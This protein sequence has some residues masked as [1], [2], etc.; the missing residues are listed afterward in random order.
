MAARVAINGYGRIGR[1]VLRAAKKYKKDIEF[2][3]LHD[4]ADIESM[5]MVTKYDSIHGRFPGE[6]AIRGDKLVIDGTEIQV[7]QGAAPKGG[8][9]LALPWAKYGVDYVVEST[10]IFRA[11]SQLKSHLTS[12]AKRV[13][14]T[15]PSKDPL[16]ATI[17]MGVNDGVLRPDHTIISNSS[18]TTNCTAPVAQVLHENWGIRSGYLSTV[19]AFTND[20]RLFDF[21]HKDFRRA[22]MATQSIIPT[23]TGAAE[24]LGRV[25]PALDGRV[26]G[27]AFRVPVPTG[28]LIDLTVMLEKEATAEAINAAMQAAAAGPLKGVMEYT[29]DPIVSVDIIGNPHSVIFDAQ[30]THVR[31]DRMA[32]VVGWYDN[33]WG[34]SCRV[35]DLIEK[36]ARMDGLSS[37]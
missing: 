13:V 17:V 16:E 35:C 2:V 3:A 32:K 23:S 36:L 4:L 30:L 11:E 31:K 24:A 1:L 28:S 21:P 19:H 6:V 25:I 15:V 14:L 22:R 5:A 8:D 20:Q 33:E 9:P 7:L 18:C 12:G 37:K 27:I 10:G 29:A 34:Y 26:E